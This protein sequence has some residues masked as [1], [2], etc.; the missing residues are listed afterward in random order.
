MATRKSA[1]E[2]A[3]KLSGLN[4]KETVLMTKFNPE[5]F[6]DEIL[7][8]IPIVYDKNGI[9]WRYN[10]EEGIWKNNSE[11]LLRTIIRKN[12]LG[13]EQQKKHYIDEI[14]SHIKDV[15]YDLN[16]RVDNNPYLVAF[17]NGIYD[18]KEQ[19]FKKFSPEHKISNKL[20]WDIDTSS[21]HC[22]KIDKFF[23]DCVGKEYKDILYDI[24]AYCLFKRYPYPKLFF[25]YGPSNTG[26]SKFLELLE[27]FLGSQNYCSVEPQDIQKD[28]HA[29]S[30]MVYKMANIVSDINYDA[31]DNINQVKK[32]T[33]EDM[34]KIREMWKSPY[35]ERIFAKQIFSTNKLPVVKEKTKAWYKRVYTVEFSNIRSKAYEDKFL[36][37]KLTSPE[38]MKGLA[39]NCLIKLIQ[40]YRWNFIFTYDIDDKEMQKVYE[41]LSNPILLFIEQNCN[42]DGNSFVYQWEFKDR[43]KTWLKANHFPPVSNAEINEYMR[44]N[45]TNSNRKSFNGFKTYRVW[46]GLSW[47]SSQSS[48]NFN[49]FNQFNRVSKSVYYSRGIFGTPLK[50][51][52][53][54]NES[55]SNKNKSIYL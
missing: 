52:N 54:L 24:C 44:E 16:F 1:E 33:G 27:N 39:M 36:M 53:L 51:L 48:H 42:N 45:Y 29:T 25:I 7:K 19:R 9:L 37:E 50:L 43:L 47:K 49:Q 35:N 2:E 28:I 4:K 30:Q 40:M 46:A 3:I 6:A 20:P 34:V 32:I 15:T 11:Q 41:K 23:E 10:D 13:E 31:L 14:L 22:P 55:Y 18:L 38:E 26:K 5:P 17:N 12:L 21:I 8:R